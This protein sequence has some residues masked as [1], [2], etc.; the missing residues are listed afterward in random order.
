[1]ILIFS[2]DRPSKGAVSDPTAEDV[3]GADTWTVRLR[4]QDP[5]SVPQEHEAHMRPSKYL[6][7]QYSKT[8]LLKSLL[9]FY[10]IKNFRS[11]FFMLFF[12][13]L[14]LQKIMQN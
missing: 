3:H 13:V 4:T 7:G 9:E 10:L 8:S 5:H 11:T 14:C 6:Q 2:G 1:M 12:Y